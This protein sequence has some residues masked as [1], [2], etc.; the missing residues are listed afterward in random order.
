MFFVMKC[1]E[2]KI[3]KPKGPLKVRCGNVTLPIYR[4]KS[5][6]YD[7]FTLAYYEGG[8][9]IRRTFSKLQDAKIEAE[10][11][12]VRIENGQRD[13]LRL[14]SSDAQDYALALKE[15]QPT[16][17]P[18]HAAIRE[19]VAAVQYLQAMPGVSLLTAVQNYVTRHN[20]INSSMA[21]SEI[22]QELLAAR[23]QDGVSVRYQQTLRSHLT[24]FSKAFICPIGSV[25]AKAIE[26]WIRGMGLSGRS[27]NNIR[28]SLITLFSFARDAGYLPKGEPTE[29]E[30]LSVAKDKGGK[31]GIFAPDQLKTL[32][33]GTEQ[34]KPTPENILYLALGAFTGARS[35]E[36]IRL[37][38]SEIRLS[39]N[40]IEIA[41]DKAKT[42]TRRL[43]PIPPNLARWLAA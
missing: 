29:A 42:A 1:Q 18:L 39:R 5:K 12:A 9:R 2:G 20:G 26:E 31:I 36:L 15:L 16:G 14:A 21:V 6:G 19:Y 33:Y 8:K 30:G 7:F 22:V 11:A 10:K 25:H 28:V 27:R 38:W 17:V 37:E 13:I 43:I 24:R 40:V 34:R 23:K 35:A 32:L 3:G 4:G 41:A